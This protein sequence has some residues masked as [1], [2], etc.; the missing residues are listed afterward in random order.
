V[1]AGIV[2]KP[3][4]YVWSSD[5]YYRRGRGPDWLDTDQLLE[6]LG[7]RRSV[8][9]RAYRQLMREEAAVPYEEVASW[10]QAVKGD[11]P[12]AIRGSGVPED[13]RTEAAA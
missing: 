4:E 3:E 1:K 2:V 11:K 9:I 13:W 8:A 10:G 7:T 5:R 12:Q 6:M